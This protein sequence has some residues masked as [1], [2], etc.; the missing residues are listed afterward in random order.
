MFPVI[1]DEAIFM[2]HM[3]AQMTFTDTLNIGI[4]N[5]AAGMAMSVFCVNN[6]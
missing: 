1:L 3:F 5:V 2:L 6:P 4:E